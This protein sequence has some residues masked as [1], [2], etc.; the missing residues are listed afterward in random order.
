[1]LQALTSTERRLLGSKQGQITTSAGR[2]FDAVASLLDLRHHCSF[3]AEAAIALEAL[4]QANRSAEVPEYI[5][6]LNSGPDRWLLDWE[7]LIRSILQDLSQRPATAIAVG[8]HAALAKGIL[9]MAQKHGCR[10]IALAG[11][12]FQNRLLLEMTVEGLR[13]A[14][15]AVY[16]PQVVPANDGG[17]ALGQVLGLI[18]QQEFDQSFDQ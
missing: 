4:A 12:C 17:L 3:E 1:M 10:Q 2:L 14:G 15:F 9:K 11:G 8:F 16:W 18:R 7:N 6:E 5:V 13:Q